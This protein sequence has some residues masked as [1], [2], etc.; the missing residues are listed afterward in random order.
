MQLQFV[1]QW[2]H[3]HYS[4]QLTIPPAAPVPQEDVTLEGLPGEASEEL[5]MPDAAVGEAVRVAFMLQNHSDS[6]HFK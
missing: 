3:E 6:K 1:I 2:V 4:K 5:R